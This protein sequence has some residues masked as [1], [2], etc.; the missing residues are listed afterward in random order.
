[1]SSS[2]S[3]FIVLDTCHLE[4]GGCNNSVSFACTGAHAVPVPH[5]QTAQETYPSR[6]P[7]SNVAVKYTSPVGTGVLYVTCIIQK[8][9]RNTVPVDQ[10]LNKRTLDTGA[11]NSP[12]F[13]DVGKNA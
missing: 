1:M 5:M 13:L 3:S 2:T 7:S 8:Q 6:E 10:L 11:C 4:V 12:V 9:G